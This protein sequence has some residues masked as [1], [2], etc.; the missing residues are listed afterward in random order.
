[1]PVYLDHNATSPIR[2]EA[3][4]A[5]LKAMAIGG[6]PSSVH[7]AGRCARTLLENARSAIA[8][9]I[10]TRSQDLTFTSGGTE[11]NNLAIAAALTCPDV[12]RILVSVLEHDA[13]W[14]GA[15]ATGYPVEI[16]PALPNGQIDLRWLEQR[17]TNWDRDTEGRPFA[18]LQAVT[19]ETGVIQPIDEA[20]AMI[21]AAEGLLLVDAV[22]TLGKTGFHFGRSGAHYASISAHKVGGPQGVGALIVSCDAPCDL[23]RRGGGQEKGRRSGT[24]NVPGA[25]GFAAAVEAAVRDEEQYT[26]L[27][28][29]RDKAEIAIRA[30]APHAVVIGGD[31]PRTPNCLAIAIP[32]WDGGMQVIALDLAGICI[33]AGSAC[34][35]GKSTA[36]RPWTAIVGEDLAR[37]GIRVS[38]GW[39]TTEADIDQFIKAWTREY[40][41]VAP[42]LKEIA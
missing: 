33:S 29:L 4:D 5:M 15:H 13:A 32:G 21:R 2:P 41:R 10:G 27:A 18:C 20:G 24:E 39:S 11:S 31:V 7:G 14:M 36:P 1:M 35:S 8:K 42:R 28:A 3:R 19:S 38:L 30:A 26:G 22:Q 17:L 34:S 6:N 40:A 37:C 12:K 23:P 9:A 25:C 16:V